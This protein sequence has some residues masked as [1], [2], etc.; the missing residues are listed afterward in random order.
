MRSPTQTDYQ[1][2]SMIIKGIKMHFPALKIIG[3]ESV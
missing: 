1:I 2:Q 3:E